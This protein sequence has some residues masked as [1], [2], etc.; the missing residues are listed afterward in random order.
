VPG[1]HNRTNPLVSD[2][3]GNLPDLGLWTLDCEAQ[4]TI[5]NINIGVDSNSNAWA[6]VNQNNNNFV[7]WLNADNVTNG[8]FLSAIISV[9]STA[10]ANL[11]TYSNQVAALSCRAGEITVTSSAT[12]TVVTFTT[13]FAPTISSN[14]ALTFGSASGFA[15]A[16]NPE[17]TLKTTNGFTLVTSPVIGG[18]LQ[19]YLATPDQ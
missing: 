11:Q 6:K 9:N 13:P 16:P 15:T 1:E 3:I 17:W 12:T 7:S 4:F 5:T 19:D 2:P 14:Y 10:A 8:Y 18:G